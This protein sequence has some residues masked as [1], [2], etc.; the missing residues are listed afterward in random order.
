MLS[1]WLVDLSLRDRLM[2]QIMAETGL[3]RRAVS[4]LLVE[5]VF[6]RVNG[7]P[8]P[9]GRA[10][11]KGM[12]VRPFRLSQQTSDLL[13]RYIGDEH[14]GDYVRWLFPSPKKGNT[15]PITPSVVNNILLRACVQ[16]MF[17]LQY[18]LFAKRPTSVA[19]TP[20]VMPFANLW[21]AP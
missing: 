14:P 2:L 4:W 16:G 19:N 7:A 13:I 20:T 15:Q 3:R 6:D 9:T 18:A 10:L 12:I 21:F 17:H 8:L 1:P 5:S 11:E